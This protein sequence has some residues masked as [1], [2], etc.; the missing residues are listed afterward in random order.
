MKVPDVLGAR[1]ELSPGATAL[2]DTL[3]GR[4]F[5]YATASDRAGRMARHLRDGLG[6]RP[7]DRVAVLSGNRVEVIELLIACGRIGALLVPLN[8]RLSVPELAGILDDCGAAV[9]LCDDARAEAAERLDAKAVRLGASYERALADVEPLSGRSW[10]DEHDP[11]YLLYTSGTTGRPKGVIQTFGMAVANHLN[12]GTAIGLTSADTTLNVLPTFHT[13]GINLYTLPTL[14][15]GGAAI[16]QHEFDPALALR[17]L[18]ERGTAFFGVPTMYQLLRDHP[19]FAAADLSG[20]R[21]WACGGAALPVP[22]LRELAGLGIVVRQGMGMTETGPTLFLI[23][24]AHALSKA[25]SVGKP[26]LFAEVKLIDQHGHAA[27][28]GELLI[29]GPGITPGYWNQPEVTAAAFT[30]DGWLRSG[31]VARRDADGYYTIVDRVK[32]MYISG[33]EN[34]YPAEVERVLFDHPAVAEAAVVGVPDARWGETGKAHL[35]LRQGAEIEPEEVRAFCRERLAGYKVPAYVEVVEALPRNAAGKILK[36]RLRVVTWSE[37]FTVGQRDFDRF[38]AL[39]GDDNPL[40][41]DP[42]YAATTRFGGTVAHGMLLFALI[43]TA[44]RRHHPRAELLTQR[45]TFPA[46]TRAGER[47]TVTARASADELDLTVTRADGTTVCEAVST[48]GK[49]SSAPEVPP[50]PA[51]TVRNS[52][53]W[54]DRAVGRR[55]H[56]E[57]T[58]TEEDL[59][60]YRSLSED[61]ADDTV[62]EPLVA[63]LFSALLGTDLPGNG[64]MY[65]KQELRFDGHARPGDSLRA[66]VTISAVR[67][68]KALVDLRTVATIGTRVVCQGEALV[69]ARQFAL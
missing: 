48:I 11:W 22:L 17:L 29:R 6:V 19:D 41:V 1:A 15:A 4:E 68:E 57:R 46:P 35:V 31:D 12:I 49:R 64:T 65:L 58:F 33:G 51:G 37:T 66:E 23:D 26:Q 14:L 40:H 52:G 3:S 54:W 24:E 32:D 45:L 9:V 60:G 59:A 5:D 67:P 43:R 38:A 20:V 63:G 69:M 61:T 2:V 55:A 28:E 18:A 8:W 13:G 25:G 39:T 34:V 47:V 44:V 10:N 42:G 36:D 50:A 21:S 62:P 27:D 16:V 30:E 56:L 7:G 53:S